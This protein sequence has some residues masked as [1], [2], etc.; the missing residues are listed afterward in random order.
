MHASKR[1]GIAGRPVRSRPA[2]DATGRRGQKSGSAT[3]WTKRNC[4][5]VIVPASP[6]SST[7][8]NARPICGANAG[9]VFAP[10]PALR[11]VINEASLRR[12]RRLWLGVELLERTTSRNRVRPQDADP[13]VILQQRLH[14][15]RRQ[16]PRFHERDPRRETRRNRQIELSG[17]ARISPSRSAASTGPPIFCSWASAAPA[18]SPRIRCWVRR[19]RFGWF[20]RALAGPNRI[21]PKRRT[22][23][24]QL[25][26]H[27]PIRL[28]SRPRSGRLRPTPSSSLMCLPRAKPRTCSALIRCAASPSSAPA[29]CRP[30]PWCAILRSNTPRRIVY[31]S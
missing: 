6:R 29:K 2:R 26:D 5:C 21:E 24:L 17:S 16:L 3:A 20:P 8:R 28:I 19:R 7:T 4:S 31:W 12:L 13:S 22:S 1:A 15:P 18:S 14:L 10:D 30:A 11:I 23:R 25:E 27:R 9:G